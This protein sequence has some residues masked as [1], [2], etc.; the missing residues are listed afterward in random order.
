MLW[1]LALELRCILHIW[2]SSCSHYPWN[3]IH[4]E[5]ITA[6]ILTKGPG[7]RSLNASELENVTEDYSKKDQNKQENELKKFNLLFSK[8]DLHF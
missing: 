6:S 2:H 4:V 1:K 7:F 5:T 8:P 3:Q